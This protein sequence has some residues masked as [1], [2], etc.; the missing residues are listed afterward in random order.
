MHLFVFGLGY[1][2]TCLGRRLLQ[3]GWRVSGTVRE[4]ERQAKLA[5]EGFSVHRFD[6]AHSLASDALASVT[7]ILS[8]APPDQDG[9][10]VLDMCGQQIA[11]LSGLAWVGYLSTTGVYGDHQGAWVDE[12]TPPHPNL[13]RARRRLAAEDGWLA[14]HKKQGLPVHIFRLAGIYGPGRSVLDDVRAGTAKRI[15]RPGQVF[16]RIHV[17]D[18]AGVL[19]ASFAH[20]NPGAIYNV[21]D[22]DPAPPAEVTAYACAL[23]GETPPPEIAF[24]D[25]GL[26]P[27]AAS[28]WADNKRVRNDRIKR[29]LGLR[30]RFPGYREGLRAIL[31]ASNLAD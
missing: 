12:A 6:R 15:V 26:S 30:L 23:L 1:S 11:A 28:F 31:A 7:H 4:P 10:P 18:I 29:E 19:E 24:A 22:D 14:F 27:M 16:S 20:P 5:Q 3:K 25:A 8:S 13:D 2:A 9:D 17:E 21:C